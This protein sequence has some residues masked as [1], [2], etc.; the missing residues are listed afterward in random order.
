MSAIGGHPS[1]NTHP[2]PYL[3]Y[4]Q[5][6]SSGNPKS[7]KGFHKTPPKF[8]DKRIHPVKNKPRQ[9]FIPNH[10]EF[11]DRGIP[12]EFRRKAEFNRGI[13]APPPP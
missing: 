4:R 8:S 2:H 9:G 12:S 1:Q 5:F 7:L 11:P 3:T 10:P 13:Y 6:P